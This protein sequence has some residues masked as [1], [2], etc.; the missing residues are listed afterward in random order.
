M[1]KRQLKKNQSIKRVLKKISKDLRRMSSEE[2]EAMLKENEPTCTP[3]Y[4]KGECQGM[5]YCEVAR[6]FREN[7]IPK[8]L[9]EQSLNG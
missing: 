4:C 9:E 7:E 3:E 1:H 2:F 5:G 8:I 6:D